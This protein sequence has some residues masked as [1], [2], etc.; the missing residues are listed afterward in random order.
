MCWKKRRY[1]IIFIYHST[2]LLW[3]FALLENWCENWENV[4]LLMY[5]MCILTFLPQQFHTNL[6]PFIHQWLKITQQR[7]RPYP[8]PDNIP[9]CCYK[10]NLI[11]VSWEKESLL[12]RKWCTSCH[13]LVWSHISLLVEILQQDF[14][15]FVVAD[16]AELWRDGLQRLLHLW[17]HAFV[18][19]VQE[20]AHTHKHTHT[21]K[22][23]ICTSFLAST[24]K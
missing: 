23:H 7:S 12:H 20:A 3:D 13:Q 24:F 14:G 16:A 22:N 4:T 17:R 8:H 15:S 1:D 18:T 5:N 21:L 6:G 10:Q 9:V 19:A 2:Q 11:G